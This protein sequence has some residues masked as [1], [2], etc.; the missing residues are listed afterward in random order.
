MNYSSGITSDDEDMENQMVGNGASE[1]RTNE[2]E[3][4][5]TL[6]DVANRMALAGE[7]TPMQEEATHEH[8]KQK[9]DHT[10]LPN[11]QSDKDALETLHQIAGSKWVTVNGALFTYRS[12]LW[13]QDVSGACHAD[14]EGTAS[15]SGAAT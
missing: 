6:L 9:Q 14:A 3:L 5:E 1:A 7:D 2:S 11:P 4:S 8:K 13:T 10:G 12:G 15:A